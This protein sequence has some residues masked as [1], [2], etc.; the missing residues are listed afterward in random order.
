MVAGIGQQ[1]GTLRVG[2]VVFEKEYS[3]GTAVIVI[4]DRRFEIL[5]GG[6]ILSY[7][8]QR[9]EHSGENLTQLVVHSDGSI[10]VNPSSESK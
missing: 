6:E 1:H 4:Q 2:E 9:Y 10:T 8:G 3:L 5:E 7:A